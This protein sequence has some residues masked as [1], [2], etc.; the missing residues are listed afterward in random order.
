MCCGANL[1]PFRHFLEHCEH[2]ERGGHQA[3]IGWP[4][5]W[6]NSLDVSENP[7][8]AIISFEG[9]GNDALVLRVDQPWPRRMLVHGRPPALAMAA[10]ATSHQRWLKTHS[11]STSAIFSAASISGAAAIRRALAFSSCCGTAPV[12]HR[13]I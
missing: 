9:H 6:I 7:Q 3:G 8:S 13:A 10:R 12:Q 4:L 1:N 5:R 11:L 2:V